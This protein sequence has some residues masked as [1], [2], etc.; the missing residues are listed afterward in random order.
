MK[1]FPCTIFS[2]IALFMA[3]SSFAQPPATT[4]KINIIPLPAQITYGNGEYTLPTTLYIQ[5]RKPDE[6]KV[7]NLLKNQFKQYGKSV[8]IITTG[9][10]NI[11][12]SSSEKSITNP[13]GYTLTV[14]RNNINMKA[15][16]PAGL[17]YAAQS[18]FQLLPVDT[19]KNITITF[20]NITD[21]PAFKWRGTMLDVS[22]HF[23]P[24]SF[25]KKFIDFL[26]SY[27]INTFHWHLTD[28]QGWRIQI[29][30]YPKLTQLGAWRKETIIGEMQIQKAK[31]YKYD[32]I[33]YGGFYTQ[34]EIKEIVAY[35]QERF[36][37]IV[38]EIEMPGHSLPVLTAYPELACKEGKYEVFTKWG[39]TKDIICPTEKSIQFF[40]DVLKELVS[41]FPGKYVHIGG[42][43]APKDVWK[44]SDAVKK[45]MQDN[46]ITEVEKVQG[47]FNGRIEKFLNCKG[48]TLVGW[49]EILEGGISPN[50]VVMSWRGEKG[51]IEAAKHKNFVVMTPDQFVYL[52]YGQNPQIYHPLEPIM[53]GEYL[54]LKKVY[55]YNPISPE[56][57]AAYHPYILG[58]QANLWTEYVSTPQKAEYMLFPRLLAL[59]EIAWTNSNKK[60]YSNFI[61]RV[62]YNLLQLDKKNVCYRIP[63][64]TGLDSSLIMK[65][66]NKATITLSSII[67]GAEIR[68]TLDG[69]MP[70]ET[71]YLYLNSIEL[72]LG[73]NI[74]IKAVS[75]AP[76]KR[77]S[78]PEE[79]VIQ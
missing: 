46:K 73:R 13:E 49:D 62:G 52:D 77:H 79:I 69:H 1:N 65:E 42:D 72:P 53:I 2:F 39:V 75:I 54:S 25:V 74:I 60:D 29:K 17:Y 10:A 64:P 51:G 27:K 66:G 26:A 14:S 31:D 55:N 36:V 61:N 21:E 70:D 19:K 32:G 43:E 57:D 58:V 6:L 45:I 3:M 48:K 8:I 68:Y 44:E 78:V 71:T 11:N 18:F 33:E 24:V 23:F 12:L 76:N 56:L 59:S 30:K 35:A 9:K 16:S 5:A 38:P 28:D 15:S 34:E 41:L 20:L 22:R 50:A 7:A 67:P 47:W 4:Q 63:E 40:E 37:T